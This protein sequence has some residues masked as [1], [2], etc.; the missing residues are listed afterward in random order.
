VKAGL[1]LELVLHGRS[2]AIAEL[3]ERVRLL[4]ATPADVLVQGEAGSGKERVAKCLHQHARE[5]GPF[6]T[7]DC[8][9]VPAERIEIELFGCERGTFGSIAAYV[10]LLERSRGG[11]L[12]IDEIDLLP[13][14]MQARLQRVLQERT[15]MRVGG[16][17]P[18]G[19]ECRVVASTRADL[20]AMVRRNTFKADLRHRI[21]VAVLEVPA[22]RD[23]R[24]DIAPLYEALLEQAGS[25]YNRPA[26]SVDAGTLQEIL[27]A[28]WPGNVRELEL[29]ADR[30][31]LGAPGGPREG[32]S[33]RNTF[34]ESVALMERTLLDAAL[35]RHGGSVKA[36]CADL[37]LTPPT[38]YRKLKALE[39][40]LSPYKD[41]A[42]DQE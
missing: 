38:L 37:G 5:R 30:A 33:M 12:F 23:R 39:M 2:P 15:F 7:L 26:P 9:A 13:P 32:P 18:I 28:D 10:G 4:A 40:D 11:T 31:V 25:R 27:A 17:D 35:R 16:R 21:S 24:A 6:V 8:A 19:A 1:P 42:P 36:A 34:D 3:R 41:D 29:H 14:W 22:L 20:D